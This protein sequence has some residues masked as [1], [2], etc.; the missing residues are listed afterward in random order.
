MNPEARPRVHSVDA[1]R[2]LVMLSMVF[3]NDIAGGRGVPWWMKHYYDRAGRGDYNGMTW[4]DWIFPAFI[5]VVGMS[6]PLSLAARLAGAAP[7]WRTA[8]HA[9]VR[10]VL[11]LVIGVFMVNRP[12]GAARLGWP[13]GLWE[14]LMFTGAMLL[15][16]SLPKRWPGWIEY[17]ARSVGGGLLLFLA[18]KYTGPAGEQFSPQWWGILGLI[19]WAYLVA[20]LAFLLIGPR[21][22]GLTAAVAMLVC[23]YILEAAGKLPALQLPWIRGSLSLGSQVA[24]HGLI[25]LLGT[26]VYLLVQP[27][28]EAA[29]TATV[30]RTILSAAGMM[31]LAAGLCY[32][33]YGINKDAA[34]PA[35]GLISCAITTLLFGATWWWVD[36]QDGLRSSWLLRLAGQNALLIYL[37]QSAAYPFFDLVNFTAWGRLGVGGNAWLYGRAAGLA[38]VLTLLSA[39]ISRL[40]V[41]LRL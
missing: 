10:V 12:A 31:A 29:A 19:G 24:A 20:L 3:A 39:A 38:I 6:V 9:M 36:R 37:L 13:V 15:V 2:G 7:V 22:A 25:A 18:W 30:G 1:L 32:P 14:T 26:L 23:V 41:R 28:V 34:T 40:G 35:W 33:L 17:V 8:L 4:V 16:V 21:P 27:A 5:F 11:L